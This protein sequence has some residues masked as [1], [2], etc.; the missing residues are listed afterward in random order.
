GFDENGNV[1]QLQLG[2]TLEWD[3]RNQLQQ[4]R[5][6]VRESGNDDSERYIYDA[7]GQR[8]RKVRITQARAVTHCCEVRYLPGLEIRTNTATGE[9]LHVITVRAGRSEVR[10]LHWQAGKSEGIDNDQYRYG[11]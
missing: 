8:V 10:V 11:L 6:V 4:V 2:Q 1:R 9:V 3:S 7:S 5:P